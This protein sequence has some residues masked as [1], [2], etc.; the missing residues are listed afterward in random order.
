MLFRDD[1][2]RSAPPWTRGSTSSSFLRQLVLVLTLGRAG[3]G[4]NVLTTSAET[5]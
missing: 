4:A 1:T 3:R 5:G 2:R